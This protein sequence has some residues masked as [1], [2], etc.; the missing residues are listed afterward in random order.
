MKNILPK[1]LWL[2][3]PVLF[4]A[5]QILGEQILP[6]RFLTITHNENGP[7]EFLQFL[8][9]GT[10]FF[11]AIRVLLMPE[12]KN[13]V[14][15]RAWAGLAA[16]CCFYVAGEEISWGQHFLGWTTPEFWSAI[17]D[18]NETNLHNT[19]KWLDQKPKLLLQIGVYGGGLI[20]P[21]IMHYRPSWVPRR[22]SAIY[23]PRELWVTALIAFG[24]MV[25]H[26]IDQTAP[27]F[28]LFTRAN[29]VLELYLYYFTLLYLITL[30]QRFLHPST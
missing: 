10:A 4:I 19:S 27:A 9:V 14:W 26:K 5:A 11:F 8:V 6:D 3:I 28:T 12:L 24:I 20:L 15:V 29:E 18:Q 1:Y 7:H 30:R 17:N 23:P 25:F 16:L 2:W 13:R 22:F 21:L